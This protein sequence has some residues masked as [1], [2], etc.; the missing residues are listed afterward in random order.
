MAI[1]DAD[2]RACKRLWK[3]TFGDTDSYIDRIFS[4]W[5]DDGFSRC[6]HDDRG[7]VSAMLCAHAFAFTGGYRG[8]YLHGLAT[9]PDCRRQGLMTLLLRTTIDRARQAGF[10]F[11]FLI[12]ASPS[13]RAWYAALGFAD[14][15]PRTS[16]LPPADSSSL[17]PLEARLSVDA[18]QQPVSL[19][20]S[21]EDIAAVL[22]E[23][24]DTPPDPTRAVAPGNAP[25]SGE[26]SQPYGQAY[27]LNPSVDPASIRI[28][29]LMD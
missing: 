11:L 22:S 28:A 24:A 20:H 16:G 5:V 15:A 21:P 4:C 17:T 23:A 14:T 8:L 25:A 12:P 13:L 1:P 19:I 7:E 2:I 18:F 29:Y 6:L 26:N 10:D 3:E 27:I 9:R